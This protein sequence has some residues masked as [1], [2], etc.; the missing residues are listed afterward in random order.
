MY[1]PCLRS[2][3]SRDQLPQLAP[4]SSFPVRKIVGTVTPPATQGPRGGG[5]WHR[6]EGLGGTRASTREKLTQPRP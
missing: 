5:I 4:F 2:S 1:Y 6:P 3:G